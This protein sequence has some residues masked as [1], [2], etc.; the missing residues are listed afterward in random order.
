MP[1]ETAK[2]QEWSLEDQW[3]LHSRL[4]SP[5]IFNHC[6]KQILPALILFTKPIALIKRTYSKIFVDWQRTNKQL[7]ESSESYIYISMTRIMLR[8]LV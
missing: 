3:M 5:V 2:K 4:E 6:K 7:P 1:T 8:R